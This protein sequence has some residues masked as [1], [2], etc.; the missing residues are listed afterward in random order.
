MVFK[1]ELEEALGKC[2][3]DHKIVV[4]TDFIEG[5]IPRIVG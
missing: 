4:A 1:N 5:L 2:M 3:E